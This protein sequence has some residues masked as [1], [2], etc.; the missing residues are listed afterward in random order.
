[1]LVTEAMPQN[2][3]ITIVLLASNYHKPEMAGAIFLLPTILLVD[4][5]MIITMNQM[6]LIT[7]LF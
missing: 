2:L 1:M 6:V 4:K 3:A 5:T 7:F